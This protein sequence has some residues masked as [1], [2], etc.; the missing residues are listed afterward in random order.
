MSSE[1]HVLYRQLAN[2]VLEMDEELTVTLAEDTLRNGFEALEAINRGLVPGMMRAGELYEQEEYFIPELLLCSDAMYAGLDV[3]KP[4]I[5]TEHAAEKH[6]VVLGVV[7]GDTH[8]IGKNLVKIMLET[9]GFEVLDLGR[10]VPPRSFV[11][12]AWAARAELIALSTLMTTT[13][14]G[15]ADVVRYVKEKETVPRTQIIVGGG[16][17]SSV[18]AR[19]IGADGYA[20][21][22]S[23]AVKLAKSLT[24]VRAQ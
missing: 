4:H 8:D 15:M 2:A 6:L 13:M 9:S 3:L 12:E 16:P 20:P 1:S 14:E 17:V 21:S 10:D 22:A 11:S 5:K 19:K 7:E 24:G 18:F 23:E